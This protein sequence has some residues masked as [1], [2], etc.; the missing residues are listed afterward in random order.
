MINY[1]HTNPDRHPTNFYPTP[2]EFSL[3]LSRHFSPIK[4]AVIDEPC[5]GDGAMVNA[6]KSAWKGSRWRSADVADFGF[7]DVKNAFD[8][9]R[10]DLIITNPPYNKLLTP[11]VRHFLTVTN[12]RCCLLLRQTFLEGQARKTLIFDNRRPNKIVI[13]SNRMPDSQFGHA[14][15]IW[16]GTAKNT[17]ILWDFAK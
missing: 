3:V 7:G 11:L 8:L 17:E 9:K 12:G 5:C 15:F 13:I 4:G 2:P 1:H 6:L 14:W 10:S 16:D